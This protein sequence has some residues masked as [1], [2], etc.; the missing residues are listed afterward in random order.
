MTDLKTFITDMM[1]SDEKRGGYF[2]FFF[3]SILYRIIVH[4]RNYCYEA[5]ILK[6]QRLDCPVVSIGNI[7]VGGT[8]KTPMVIM[9]A[10]TLKKEGFRPAVLSRGYGG[11]KRDRV[12]IVSDGKN[13]LMGIQEAGDEPLLMAQSLGDVP[14]ITGKKRYRTGRYAIDNLKADILLLDDAFQHRSLKRDI[15]IVLL[16]GERP[17]GNGYMLPRGMLRESKSALKRADIVVLTGNDGDEKESEGE[18]R[19]LRKY[20][21]APVFFASR[22]P[23]SVIDGKTGEKRP[24]EYL[25]GKRICAFSG[26]AK[27]ENFRETLTS[28]GGTIAAFIPFPDHHV[29]TEGDIEEIARRAAESSAE[30]V[31][32]T[33][34]DG[35]KLIDLPRFLHDMYLLKIDM[36]FIPSDHEF[37]TLIL[38]RLRR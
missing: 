7:T 15:D 31:I 12:N 26:I 24:L 1:K 18:V 29:Y 5:R 16:D 33:E 4:L 11:K 3:L 21:G 19:I 27:P 17:F 30:I 36:K 10:E 14:V 8:G 20:T 38:E 28:L 2:P 25:K 23:N 9:L 13:I 22:K 32:T 35:V 6:S 34:K 37:T